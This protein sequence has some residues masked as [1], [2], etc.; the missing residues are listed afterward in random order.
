MNLKIENPTIEA[1]LQ[2]LLEADEE[3]LTPG[4]IEDLDWSVFRL[5]DAPK[6]SELICIHDTKVHSSLRVEEGY[7]TINGKAYYLCVPFGD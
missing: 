5:N 6:G 4:E 1:L 3:F 7:W 2:A